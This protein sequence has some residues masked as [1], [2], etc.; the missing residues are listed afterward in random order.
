[1]KKLLFVVLMSVGV[2]ANA[3]DKADANLDG[4]LAFTQILFNL[5]PCVMLV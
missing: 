4:C 1:M 2:F 3:A 5:Q